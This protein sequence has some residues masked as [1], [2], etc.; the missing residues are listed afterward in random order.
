[1]DETTLIQT[2]RDSVHDLYRFVSLRC[3]GDPS[4][5]EDV[6]QETWLRAVKAWRDQGL[7]DSPIAWLKTVARNLLLNHFRRVRTLSMES[8]PRD[9]GGEIPEDGDSWTAPD[10]ATLL[11]WG[12]ARLKPHQSRLLETFHMEG[13]SVREIARDEGLSDRAVEGRLRRARQKLRKQLEPM[14]RNLQEGGGLQ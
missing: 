12:L 3:G 13:R 6:T 14:V 10:H 2:Y 9:W 4:L 11:T 7:P 5:A 1:M 8:L